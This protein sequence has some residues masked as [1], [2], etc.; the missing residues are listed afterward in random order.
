MNQKM[1]AKPSY[2]TMFVHKYRFLMLEIEMIFC[3][4]V[5]TL[6]NPKNRSMGS[7]KLNSSNTIAVIGN[8][9]HHLKHLSQKYPSSKHSNP[10]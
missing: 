9:E 7:P 5:S 1:A 8:R 6:V 3:H 10:Y 2:P 4:Y